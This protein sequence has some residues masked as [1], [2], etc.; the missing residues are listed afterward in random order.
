MFTNSY[1]KSFTFFGSRRTGMR[2][3]NRTGHSNFNGSDLA[4]LFRQAG[5]NLEAVYLTG[6][7]VTSDD[8][9][10]CSEAP[11]VHTLEIGEGKHFDNSICDIIVKIFPN[12]KRLK[13][14]GMEVTDYRPLLGLG[15][16]ISLNLF[17]SSV[18]NDALEVFGQMSKLEDL[19][20]HQTQVTEHGLSK[21][22]KLSQLTWLDLRGLGIEEGRVEELGARFMRRDIRISV[23]EYVSPAVNAL[24]EDLELS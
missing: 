3:I 23:G 15:K 1:S 7:G 12:L 13:M 5:T 18:E 10:A 14:V 17:N 2:T 22:Y 6:T 4:K 21:L 19:C 11:G 20:L 9:R 16:L 8:I 24:E